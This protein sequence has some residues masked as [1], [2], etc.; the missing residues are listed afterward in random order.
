MKVMWLVIF[1][2]LYK[3]ITHSKKSPASGGYIGP[4]SRSHT[5]EGLI[6]QN[7]QLTSLVDF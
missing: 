3:S 6:R 5:L 2:R 7:L 4:V 1:Y